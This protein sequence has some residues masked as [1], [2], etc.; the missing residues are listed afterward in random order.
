MAAMR[1]ALEAA[2]S[3]AAEAVGY[4]DHTRDELVRL[5]DQAQERDHTRTKIEE[6]LRHVIAAGI[7][8][9]AANGHAQ[10]GIEWLGGRVEPE[11]LRFAG[12]IARPAVTP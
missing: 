3:S 7:K 5:L 8:T 12:D 1:E 2:Q 11:P 9:E 4:L 10:A 6:L